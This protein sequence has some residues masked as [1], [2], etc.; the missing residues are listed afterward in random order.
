MH[1]MRLELGLSFEVCL[2][3]HLIYSLESSWCFRVCVSALGWASAFAA[4]FGL[5]AGSTAG[6]WP[7]LD[8]TLGLTCA[9]GLASHKATALDLILAW[10]WAGLAGPGACAW[11]L[12]SALAW[13]SV[14]L[15]ALV[16]P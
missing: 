8:L 10:A 1:N 4:T 3:F 13:A 5:C 11:V 14:L 16:L 15:R 12:D 6:S 2:G 7:L 9:W